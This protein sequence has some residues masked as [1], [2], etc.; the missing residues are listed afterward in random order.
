[1]LVPIFAG[2]S[3]IASEVVWSSF[4]FTATCGIVAIKDIE[5]TG[6]VEIMASSVDL[7]LVATYFK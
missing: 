5:Y 3:R 7:A 4:A 1:V 6:S 2:A